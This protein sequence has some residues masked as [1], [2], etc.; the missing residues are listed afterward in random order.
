MKI[1]A[2]PKV[3]IKKGRE[4][5][6][7]R[8]HP[9]LFSGAISQAP[10]KVEPGGIVDLVD[11]DG[12]FVARG[13]YNPLSDIAIRILT[14]DPGEDIDK[15][16]LERLL[17]RAVE[18]RVRALDLEQTNVYRVLN[19]EGDFLPGIIADRYSDVIVLQSHTA[20]GDRLLPELIPVLESELSPKAIILRNDA[21]M[22]KRE[23]LEREPPWVVYG[24][25]DL[26]NPTLDVKEN[27]LVFRVDPIS[28]QKTG[29][30]ADQRDKRLAV[31]SYCQRLPAGSILANLFSYSGAFSVY[32][33]AG[34][35]TLHT[36]NIDESTKA[37]EMARINLEMNNMS[38]SKHSFV[39]SDVFKWL[40][41][42]VHNK[43]TFDFIIVDPPAFAKSRKDREKALKAYERLNRLAFQ[44]CAAGGLLLT[45]SCSGMISLEDLQACLRS[46]SA[47]ANR[48]A[49]I[50]EVFKGSADHPINTAALE[51]EY[52]KAILCR[53]V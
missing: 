10:A 52:L 27:S 37:M 6:I 36:V 16:F 11:T 38:L 30:F 45:C 9:W 7:L 26:D 14:R 32:A 12:K 2:P 24:E 44:C 20:G 48:L 8:G 5:Q 49:Q 29:F 25:V 51:T 15:Q 43:R 18:L 53:A 33:T 19:A 41:E 1:S 50:L 21:L 3:S 40:E 22:R 23:G 13:Y 34:N 17:R 39:E 42:Q 46:A 28:G 31:K 4:W 35:P 47:D